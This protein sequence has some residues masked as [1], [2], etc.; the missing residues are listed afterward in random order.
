MSTKRRGPSL[1]SYAQTLKQ[2]PR[3]VAVKVA[4]RGAS[5]IT[6][7]AQESFSAGRTAHDD[8]R[9]TGTSGNAVTLVKSGKLQAMAIRFLHDG[10]TKIRAA[11]TERYMA[12][13][14]GR[15]RYLP[16]GQ[17]GRLPAKWRRLLG[18]TAQNTLQEEST[19]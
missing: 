14:V 11:I 13:H 7:A 19:V 5:Q 4:S 15:F 8:P 16:I 18:L 3:E 12:V 6:S 1:K 10:G 9:P 2:L 17:G